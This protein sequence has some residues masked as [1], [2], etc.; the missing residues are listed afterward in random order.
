MTWSGWLDMAIVASFMWLG[1][2]IAGT[3]VS[4]EPFAE[5]IVR[6]GPDYW[7]ETGL[8]AIW[9][10]CFLPPVIYRGRRQADARNRD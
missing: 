5:G 1:L 4:P 10:A 7:F 6:V 3:F 9:A 2:G 8:F